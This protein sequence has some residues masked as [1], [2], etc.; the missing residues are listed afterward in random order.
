MSMATVSNKDQGDL[1]MFL[2]S[3]DGEME[4]HKAELG[5]KST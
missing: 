4:G 1:A 3:D 5:I 2:G